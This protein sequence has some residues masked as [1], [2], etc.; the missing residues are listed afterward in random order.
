MILRGNIK[1]IKGLSALGLNAH[2]I[3][4]VLMEN[5][6][7]VKKSVISIILNEDLEPLTQKSLPKSVVK[8]IKMNSDQSIDI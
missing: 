2:E 4:E 5:G 7:M 8:E 6:F 3:Q 1:R